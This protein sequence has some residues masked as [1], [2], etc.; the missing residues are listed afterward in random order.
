VLTDGAMYCVSLID[1]TNLA[2]AS[3]AGMTVDLRLVGGRYVS[4]IRLPLDE[5]SC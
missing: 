2:A 4:V 5:N 3:I 1:R